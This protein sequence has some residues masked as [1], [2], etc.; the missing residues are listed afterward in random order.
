MFFFELI[1]K[2]LVYIFILC[3]L[4][5]WGLSHQSFRALGSFDRAQSQLLW[6]AVADIH[7]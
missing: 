4:L 3:V 5:L 2:I 7:Q 1:L 6:A